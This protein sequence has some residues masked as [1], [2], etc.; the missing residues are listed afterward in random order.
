M[1]SAG[2]RKAVRMMRLAGHLEL[3]LVAFVDTPGAMSGVD[4][5]AAGIGVAMAQAL[6]LMSILPIPIVS[7][8]I[9]EAGSAGALALGVGDRILMQEH[10]VFSVVGPESVLYRETDRATEAASSLKVTAR[11]C[12]RLGVVDAVLPEPSPGAHADPGHAA[13]IVRAAIVQ[14][15]AELTGA[16][17]RRLLDD[18]ARKVRMLGQATPEGQEAARLELR[19]LQELQRSISRSLGDLRDRWE[20]RQL[21]LPNLPNLPHLPALPTLRRINVHRADIADFAGRLAATGR[22]VVRS[23]TRSVR[24]REPGADGDTAATTTDDAP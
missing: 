2:Y 24:G 5:E 3:P 22:E 13:A 9:G 11:D 16:A 8:L 14:S 12:L 20:G 10:A 15:L 1:E 21:A 17:P 23:Q 4:A 18:R 19:E 7:V 6:G